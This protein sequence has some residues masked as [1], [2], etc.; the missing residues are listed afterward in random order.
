VIEPLLR[1][2]A[3]LA[4][5]RP[6]LLWAGLAA[7]TALAAL[8]VPRFR[9][10]PDVASLLPR[11]DP[12]ARLL[13]A[14]TLEGE[15]VRTLL[16]WLRGE[17]LA[18]Q[19]PELVAT[20]R[21]SPFLERVD[22]QFDELGSAPEGGA[23]L[24][25]APDS[26]LTDLEARLSPTGRREA[27]AEARARLAEDPLTGPALVRGDPLGLRFVLDRARAAHSPKGLDLAS[28]YLHWPQ[29]GLALVRVIGA[30]EPF[31]VD[32]SRALLADLEQRL[33][34]QS[35]E[36]LGGYDI[37]R[38]DASR[39]RADL[40]AS[41]STSIPALLLF[42]A[43]SARSLWLAHL[44]LLPCLVAAVWALGFGAVT[45]GP[46]TPLAVSGAAILIGLGVD[47]AIHY[48]D[49]YR[50]ERRQ[51][52][53]AA[54]VER[55]HLH[56]GPP[57]LLGLWT[58]VAAFLSVSFGSFPGL[59]GFGALLTLGLVSAL[60]LALS[61]GPL[62]GRALPVIERDP[63]EPWVL[64]AVRR[65]VASRALRPVALGL[66]L[67]G[68]AGWALVGSGRLLFDADPKHLRP[69]EVRYAA[70]VAELQEVL[71]SSPLG[72]R[73]WLPADRELEPLAG[74][75]ERLLARGEFARA[76]GP[77]LAVPGP[78][79]RARLAQFTARTAGF[80]AAT[81]DDLRAAGFVPEPFRAGLEQLEQQLQWDAPAELPTVTFEGQRFHE[82]VLYPRTTPAGRQQ[83][84][85]L[86]ATVRQEF[87]E[88]L[89]LMDPAGAGD[90]LGPLLAA[91]LRRALVLCAAALALFLWLSLR[92][93]RATLAAL[94]PTFVGLGL[95]VGGLALSGFPLHPGNLIALPLILGLGV[96][97]GI[98]MVSRWREQGEAAL[99]TTGVSNWRTTV[100][101]VLG[102]GSLATASS[103]AIASL[104]WL[105]AGGAL[106]CF[107]SSVVLVPALLRAR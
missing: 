86:A 53:H 43:W 80:A 89:W 76:T 51:G 48:F 8:F 3:H 75:L 36:F 98:H 88:P 81:L 18:E 100:T 26:V 16:I 30:R 10:D 35:Y 62:L 45:L 94:A 27:L 97:D 67:A 57:L 20:L 68:L 50:Q 78:E 87:G 33:A 69:P 25:Q 83:R 14:S 24:V 52:T 72:L 104:G 54:A 11:D 99:R 107:L 105:A 38:R 39:I 41:L 21:A 79:R 96:D 95:T 65:L 73:V 13:R 46:Q 47:F 59:G 93:W 44:Y 106:A 34:G 66:G 60:A 32:F 2:H 84:T 42:L 49:R 12:A 103:P 70:R 91:D 101:T 4:V 102:F 5:R 92:T 22:A 63:P 1:A 85:A 31:D 40:S 7:L 56:S 77:L 58:T 17:S 90:T 74:A 64:R 19:L 55:S 29:R 9:I 28:P 82:L 71:G 37:A 61:L 6:G 15:S 23:A